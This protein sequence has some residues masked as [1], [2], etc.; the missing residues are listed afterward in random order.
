MLAIDKQMEMTRK[1][2]DYQKCKLRVPTL[3][4]YLWDVE[5]RSLIILIMDWKEEKKF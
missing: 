5:I 1:G 3:V 4:S 2:V